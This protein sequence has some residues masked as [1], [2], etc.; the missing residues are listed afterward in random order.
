[1]PRR[2]QVF[3][4]PLGYWRPIRRPLPEWRTMRLRRVRRELHPT[5]RLRFAFLPGLAPQ[6]NVSWLRGRGPFVISVLRYTAFVYPTQRG[7]RQFH[8]LHVP[9]AISTVLRVVRLGHALSLARSLY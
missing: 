6:D 3:S 5:V 4:R 8:A 2:E 1:M 7:A 9:F